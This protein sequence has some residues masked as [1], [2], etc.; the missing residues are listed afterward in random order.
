MSNSEMVIRVKS[1]HIDI[2]TIRNG[3]A[4]TKPTSLADLQNVLNRDRNLE[5][6]LLPGHWGTQKYIM[7]G[8]RELYALSTPPH[9]RTVKYDF[10]GS[11]GIKDFKIPL[12]GM[13][14]VIIV[15]VKRE[16]GEEV[17]QVAHMMSYALRN[18]IMSE[19]DLV[20]KFPFSNVSSDY[21]C[22]GSQRVQVGG[23]KSVTTVPDQFLNGVFNSDLDS[24]KFDPFN[25]R[26]EGTTRDI[27]AA[28]TPNFFEYLAQEQKIAEAQGKNAEFRYDVLVREGRTVNDAIRREMGHLN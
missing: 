14:W 8:S 1:D 16:G 2:T 15:N 17:R 27:S 21:C 9:I 23:S 20:Y 13:L 28:M 7:R 24:H 22:W 10:R 18:W 11:E 4:S 26:K 25:W 3:V 6:P 12:P 5:T 19:R